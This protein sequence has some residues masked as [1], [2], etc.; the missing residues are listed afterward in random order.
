MRLTVSTIVI[1]LMTSVA[2]GQTAIRGMEIIVSDG[3]I[4][5]TI[6][7]SPNRDF[8]KRLDLEPIDSSGFDFEIRFYKL[9]MVTN[10]R[11]LRLVRFVAGQWESAE[12]DENHKSKIVRHPAAPRVEYDVFLMNLMKC[13]FTALPDQR[14]VDKKIEDSFPTKKEYLQSRPS[15]HDGYAFTIEF[16]I[17]NKFRVYGFYNPEVYARYYDNVEFKNYLAIQK[18]FENDLLRK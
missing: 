11:N 7:H 10:K 2:W 6:N 16:K 12:F 3:I 17:A 9:T 5:D 18:M 4:S 14:E 13:N 1:L 8:E 15:V